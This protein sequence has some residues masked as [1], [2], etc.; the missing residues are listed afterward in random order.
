MKSGDLKYIVE[1]VS[2]LPEQLPSGHYTPAGT[3]VCQG[4]AAVRGVK[5]LDGVQQGAEQ[6]SETI[7]VTMRWRDG[8]DASMRVKWGGRLYEIERVDPVPYERQ[9]RRIWAHSLRKH[10]GMA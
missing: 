7:E 9:Y 1:I 2:S 3:T 10:G 6:Y 8:I 5:A 4:F